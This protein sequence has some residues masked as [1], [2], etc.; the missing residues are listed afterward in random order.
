MPPREPVNTGEARYRHSPHADR[1]ARRCLATPHAGPSTVAGSKLGLDGIPQS[2]GN[3]RLVFTKVA[4]ALVDDLTPVDPVAQQVKNA[5]APGGNPA[6]MR[7]AGTDLHLDPPA[8]HA[9]Q[10]HHISYRAQFEI[11]PEDMA[12]HYGLS[13]IQDGSTLVHIIA[14]RDCSAHPDTLFLRG[15]DLVVDPLSGHF[16]LELSE[17]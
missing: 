5:A 6:P 13:R 9:E 3:N 4:D 2:L 15:R 8:F 11:T 7:A 12:G 10:R 16:P 14:E 17:I 1:C